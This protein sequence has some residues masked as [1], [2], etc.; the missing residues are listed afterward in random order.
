[1]TSRMVRVETGMTAD[2][3]IEVGG[4]GITEGIEVGV[5]VE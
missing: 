1:A 2:G 5:A 4:P 3:R